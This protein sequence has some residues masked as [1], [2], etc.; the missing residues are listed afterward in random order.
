MA[1]D[2]TFPARYAAAS[3]LALGLISGCTVTTGGEIATQLQVAAEEEMALPDTVDVRPSPNVATAAATPQAIA[4]AKNAD[5]VTATLQGEAAAEAPGVA[6]APEAQEPVVVASAYAGATPSGGANAA[7]VPSG[8]LQAAIVPSG[9]DGVAARS[10]ELDLLIVKYAAHYQLPVELVRRVVNRESTF[11]PA[12]RNG[13]YWGLMQIRHDTA[14]TM[15][16]RGSAEGLLDA[17]TNLRYAVKYLRGAFLT[18][19][20][21]HDRAVR[22]YARG[23]YYDAKRKGL[24]RETGLRS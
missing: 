18:A 24:L 14:R 8:V 1:P 20:G 13:P 5:P 23:Y 16:Y 19:D 11:N 10:P 22:L 6:E 7:I 2:K 12:A 9:I 15:G 3:F 4:A 21:N 17:E